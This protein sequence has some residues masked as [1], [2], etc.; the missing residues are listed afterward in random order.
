[1]KPIAVLLLSFLLLAAACQQPGRSSTLQGD[2]PD[3][4]ARTS[5]RPT[6]G[7]NAR[8]GRALYRHYCLPCHGEDGHGDGFNAYNL[9][10]KPRDLAAAEFQGKRTDDELAAVI[11]TGGGVA[12]LSTGMPPWGRTLSQ[13]Q[14]ENLVRYLRVLPATAQEE[15]GS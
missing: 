7:Y 2:R 14:I 11:R 9:D 10:P 12:G 4:A 3:P 13:R 15:T 8:E 6:L 5:L 1:M